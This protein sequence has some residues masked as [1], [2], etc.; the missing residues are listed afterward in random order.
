[1]TQ[2]LVFGGKDPGGENV[3]LI[4]ETVQGPTNTLSPAQIV[5]VSIQQQSS[6]FEVLEFPTQQ[7][8]SYHHEVF[9]YSSLKISFYKVYDN[10]IG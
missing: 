7:L 10:I 9:G 3:D 8:E 4:H 2:Y 1:M 5:F 6:S